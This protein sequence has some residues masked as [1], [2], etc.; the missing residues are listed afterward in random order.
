MGA[1]G[2][3]FDYDSDGRIDIVLVNG[4]GWPGERHQLEPTM[5]L[6]R[7]LGHGQF[8]DVTRESGLNVPMY[9]MGVSAADYDN[10]GDPDLVITGYQQT[11]LFRNNGDGTF[12]DITAQAG[13]EQ[14]LWST[15]A[16]F[17]DLDRDG[18]LD[19]LVGHYVDWDPSQEAQLDCTYGTPDKDYCAVKYF[20][21]QGLRFYRN[22]GAGRFQDATKPA[23]FAAPDAR[24]LGLVLVDYN[25]DA[26]PD[27]LVANDLTPSLFFAN[28]GDGTFRDIGVQSGLVLD[29]GGVAFAGMGIDATYVTNASQLCAA[30]GNFTGQPTTLHCQV[31]VGDTYRPDVFAERSHR[32]G[33]ARPTLRMVTFGLFFFDPDL[34]GWPDLL[35]ANGHVVNEQ[36]LRNVPYAQSPQL[37]RNQRN[38]TFVEVSATAFA[39]LD[40]QLVGRGAAYADY[41]NDGDPDVLLTSNQGSVHLLRN[42][43]PRTGH[44][45]RVVTQGTQSNRQGIGAQVRLYTEQRQLHDLVRTGGSYLS[46]SETPLTFG[47]GDERIVRLEVVWPSGSVDVFYNVASDTTFIAREGA[48]PASASVAHRQAPGVDQDSSF[49]LKRAATGHYQAGRIGAAIQVFQQILQ[50][51][52]GDYMAQQYLVELYWRQG[53]PDAARALLDSMSRAFPDAN[54]LLQ[55][56]FHMEDQRLGDLAEAIYHEAAR[57][58]PQAPEALYR[59]GKQAVLAGRYDAAL[60]Y[61]R[62]ALDRHPGFVEAHQGRGL[63]YAEQGRLTDAEAAFQQVLRLTPHHAEALTHLGQLYV[64]SK[65]LDEALAAFQTVIRLQPQQAKGYHN[66]GTVLAAQGRADEAIV[67]FQ[68][69]LRHDPHSLA[70]HND[71]GTLYAEQGETQRAIVEFQTAVQIDRRSV[72]GHYNLAMAYGASGQI[73]AMLRELQETLRLDPQH[74]EAGFNLGVGYLQSGQTEAAMQQFRTAVQMA[75]DM[76]EAHYF[77]AVAYAQL[78]K[79]DAMLAA[80]RRTIDLDASHARAHSAL[81]AVYFQRQQF[82]LARQHGNKA[83]Q[84]GASVDG[85]L[86]ALERLE[87]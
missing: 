30:I 21:G 8:K 33:L 82:D 6:Y 86:E 16:M 48:A 35:M 66:L 54:F 76:A 12:A 59:L 60:G 85:L 51:H 87:Q 45:L 24:V 52:P 23:G 11:L 75:P 56:A 57:I 49:G 58:D 28:Q 64:R 13:I 19:L 67:Q 2:G 63:A 42:D 29:E 15:A 47:L 3:F 27:I 73:D 40:L 81:A 26:W 79:I 37:F 17:A 68:Q 65:R 9:G 69:A 32:A 18:W 7:N 4:R 62:Q 41:D 25:Q 14:G 20:R 83:A 44:Y 46:H 38:G 78:G 84:L 39:G 77:L 1:G 50:R 10:D 70:T 22:L 43:T 31:Q 36:H 53:K 61:F 74:L 55:F 71:L 34:D 72:Q 5:R 80:L